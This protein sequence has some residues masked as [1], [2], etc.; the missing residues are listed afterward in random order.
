MSLAF[1][2]HLELKKNETQKL[3]LPNLKSECLL[4]RSFEINSEYKS[5]E[6]KLTGKESIVSY[7]EAVFYRSNHFDLS[8]NLSQIIDAE[9][10][11]VTVKN[12]CTAKDANVVRLSMT[13]HYSKRNEGNIIYNNVYTNFNTE[14]MATILSDIAS[15]GKHVTQIV[16]TSPNKLTSLE[17]LP[18]FESDP[19]WLKPIKEITDSHNQIVMDLTDPEKY[20]PNLIS[21]LLHYRLNVPENVEKIGVIVYGYHH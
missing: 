3:H 10:I 19:I 6:I 16:W 13:F 5:F 7:S 17:L 14:G 15:A 12:I 4:L 1:H 20:D 11:V 8:E 21:Q 18:K 2:Y 9:Y